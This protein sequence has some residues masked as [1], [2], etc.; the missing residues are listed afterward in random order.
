[1]KKLMLALL[2]F[3]SSSANAIT[4]CAPTT[5]DNIYVGDDG[6]LWMIFANGGSAYIQQS[7]PDFKNIYSLVLAAHM[8]NKPI[9]VRYSTPN[10]KCDAANRN[11][12]QGIWLLK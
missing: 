12:I 9:K 2:V 4:E 7:D 6:S 8:A 3:V 10:A 5:T 11:D 1:M